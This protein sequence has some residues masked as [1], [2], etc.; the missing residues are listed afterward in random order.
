MRKKVRFHKGCG[1]AI[2]NDVCA[3]CGKKFGR[4]D[5]VLGLEF[6]EKE[7]PDWDEHRKRIREGRDIKSK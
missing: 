4:L 5:K 7:V 6:E 1:G 3:T 2:R